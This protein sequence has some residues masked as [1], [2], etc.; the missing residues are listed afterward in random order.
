MF[1]LQLTTE[2][3]VFIVLILVLILIL[4]KFNR[5][6]LFLYLSLSLILFTIGFSMRLSGK[7]EIIDLGFFFTEISSI[8]LYTLFVLA[9]LLGQIKYWKK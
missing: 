1:L 6:D 7:T 8:W 2:V 5:K 9:L 3:F 4:K